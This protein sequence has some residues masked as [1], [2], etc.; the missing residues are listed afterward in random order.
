VKGPPI[1]EEE[2]VAVA[3]EVIDLLNKRYENRKGDI[4]DQ[5]SGLVGLGLALERFLIRDTREVRDEFK[6]IV[7]DIRAA[8]TENNN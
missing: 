3:N 4:R 8:W 5:A 6:L 7:E 1:N 2:A